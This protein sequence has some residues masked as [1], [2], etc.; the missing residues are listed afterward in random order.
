MAPGASYKLL[1]ADNM[2][3][4]LLI[5]DFNGRVVW[6]MDNPA[7]D[8]SPSAGP[9]GVR[10]LPGNRILAT[11][12]TGAVGII[13]VASKTWVWRVNGDNYCSGCTYNPFQ[14][15]YEA[16]LL[17][18]GNVAV[19]MR[20]N[21][22]GRVDVF[23]PTTGA[24]VWTHLL[25]QAHAVYY[26]PQGYNTSYPTLLIGGW[27]ETDEVAY[28]P[29]AGETGQTVTWSA[30]TEY[31]HTALPVENDNVLTVEGYYVQQLDR[32]GHRVWYVSATGTDNQ[33]QEARRVAFNPY[34][35]YIVTYIGSAQSNPQTASHIEFWDTNR[36]VVQRLQTLSNVNP[37]QS[38]VLNFPYGI[39]VIDYPG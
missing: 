38:S 16:E 30:P 33:S 34:G 28:A 35:G 13:D 32:Q 17:P 36:Q 29:R 3:R 21:Q 15:P 1:I 12:G 22:D 39:Q 23:D 19:A 5:T 9:L 2:N 11:F 37:G 8:P 18:D 7:G 14:S 26:R 25:Y 4:R 24:V 6:E 20:Y 27:G 10:W 31:T